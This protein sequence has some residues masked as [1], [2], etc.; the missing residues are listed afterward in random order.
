MNSLLVFAKKPELG[1]VKTRLAKSIGDEKALSVFKRLLF[2]TFD[3]ADQVGVYVCACLTEKDIITLEAI[4][5]DGFY[6]QE[7]GDLGER[8]LK[9]F[10]HSKV[11]GSNKTAIIGTDCADLTPDLITEAFTRL[12]KY[13]VVLGPALDGGYYLLASTEPKPYLYENID[14]STSEVLNQTIKAIEDNN[15]TYYFLDPLSDID[16]VEDLEAC[17]NP[18]FKK[19]K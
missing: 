12:D 19:Q 4:P 7:Q 8:M 16:T 3:I 5:Y 15:E 1:K 14:W 13:D 17:N 10:E 11:L 6:L 9:A 18:L 2:Y